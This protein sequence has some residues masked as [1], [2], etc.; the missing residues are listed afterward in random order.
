MRVNQVDLFGDDY[1]TIRIKGDNYLNKIAQHIYELWKHDSSL[2]I[3]ESI[4]EIN[5]KFH[6]A[7]M[8]DSGL[9]TVLNG[10]DVKENF[11]KWYLS[12]QCPTEE[13]TARALRGLTNDNLIPLP[14]NVIVKAERDRARVSSSLH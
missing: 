7:V 2:G 5:R 6:L 12:K 9:S 13:E 1:S 3:G 14:K 4:G 8:M 10:Q 11:H